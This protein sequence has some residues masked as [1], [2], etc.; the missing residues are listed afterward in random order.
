MRRRSTG[1]WSR[2]AGRA[3]SRSA[4]SAGA[5][6]EDVG[7]PR[8]WAGGAQGAVAPLLDGPDVVLAA[9]AAAEVAGNDQ[10]RRAAGL[11]PVEREVGRLGA[12]AAGVVRRGGAAG[13]VSL[14]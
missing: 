3:A 10:D 12:V 7:E 2:P 4:S 6:P 13:D 8:S 9:G 1:R 11:G 14:I 5:A